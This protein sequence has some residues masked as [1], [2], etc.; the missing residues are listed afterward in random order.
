MVPGIVCV[1]LMEMM[2]P[3]TAFSLVRER[4]RGTLEQLMVS[5]LSRWGLMLGKLTPCLC[6][7][8]LMAIGLFAVMRWLD[9]VLMQRM[10]A[11]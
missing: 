10:P 3:L 1:L 11:E 7:G 9:V 5:P 2:V 8:M 4:E 6:I